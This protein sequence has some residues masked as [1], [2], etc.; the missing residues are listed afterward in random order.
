[1]AKSNKYKKAKTAGVIIMTIICTIL[2]LWKLFL[3]PV[4]II[5]FWVA[6]LLLMSEFSKE[7]IWKS[8]ILPSAIVILCGSSMFIWHFFNKETEQTNYA[9]NEALLSPVL[10]DIDFRIAD[11]VRENIIIR[12]KT[13][14][15]CNIYG[16]AIICLS[17]NIVF[18][19]NGVEKFPA[20]DV[21]S[22]FIETTNESVAN[23]IQFEDCVITNCIFHKISFIGS[24]E[25]MKKFK[26]TMIK[27]K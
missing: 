26:E 13:I 15:N 14:S 1:M 9:T 6:I 25:Q 8:F 4:S 12:K 16:P 22:Y 3:I 10:K 5:A 19:N 11:L 18:S 24:Y 2:P 27:E 20:D 23:I 21:N 7:S 17:K